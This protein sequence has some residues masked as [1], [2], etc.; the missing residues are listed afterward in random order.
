MS[1]YTPDINHPVIADEAGRSGQVTAG[2]AWTDL[3]SDV[4][5]CREGVWVKNNDTTND[6]YVR[7]AGSQNPQGIL[8]SAGED[9]FFPVDEAKEL[10]VARAGSSSVVVS[11][12]AR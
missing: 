6:C 12:W 7:A 2:A 8:L 9:R 3:S 10:Q 1:F 11:W 5:P 4:I